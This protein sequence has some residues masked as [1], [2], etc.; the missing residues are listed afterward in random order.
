M[1]NRTELAQKYLAA[2]R[3]RDAAQIDALSASLA[4]DVSLVTPRG[5]V[6]GKQAVIDRLK[7]PPQGMGGGGGMMGQITFGS[8]V[9]EGGNVKIEANIP[10]N[11]MIKGMTFVFSFNDSDQICKLETVV[12]R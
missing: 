4:E 1:G 12:Q 2:Q 3:S 9:E 11:P 8:P 5:N 6:D 7:N 10:P